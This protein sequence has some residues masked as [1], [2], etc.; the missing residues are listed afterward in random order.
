MPPF[1]LTLIPQLVAFLLPLA[2]NAL[3][4]NGQPASA[5][6][7]SVHTWVKQAVKDQIH[8]LLVGPLKGKIPSAVLAFEEELEDLIGEALEA[9]LDKIED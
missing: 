5:T 9:E 7:P 1:I 3:G 4:L 2:Q 8:H 6:D